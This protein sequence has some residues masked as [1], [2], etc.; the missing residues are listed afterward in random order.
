MTDVID[1]SR[2]YD[3]AQWVMEIRQQGWVRL[4]STGNP[5]ADVRDR[6]WITGLH[7]RRCPCDGILAGVQV[8][9]WE[10]VPLWIMGTET[11]REAQEAVSNRVRQRALET[12]AMLQPELERKWR[13]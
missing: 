5:T 2:G 8:E 12:I 13:W 3:A 1:V 9:Y 10:W 6:L 11:P 7:T 4:K